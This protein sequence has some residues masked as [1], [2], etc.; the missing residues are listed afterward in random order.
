MLLYII[1]IN[2]SIQSPWGRQT[3]LKSGQDELTIYDKSLR[4][5]GQLQRMQD[6]S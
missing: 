4:A 2:L 1:F 6:S 5:I 3:Q